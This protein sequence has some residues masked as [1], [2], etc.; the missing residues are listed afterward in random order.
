[1][2]AVRQQRV[3]KQTLVI[4]IPLLVRPKGAARLPPPGTLSGVRG[5]KVTVIHIFAARRA[6]TLWQEVL[7]V[8]L[9]GG[10]SD[11]CVTAQAPLLPHKTLLDIASYVGGHLAV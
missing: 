7:N 5:E 10:N 4:P 8:T 6:H 9:F 2:F 1:M 11:A 3:Y